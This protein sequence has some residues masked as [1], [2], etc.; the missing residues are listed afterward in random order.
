MLL[1]CNDAVSFRDLR[2]YA[3]FRVSLHLYFY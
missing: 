1:F 2:K 3:C